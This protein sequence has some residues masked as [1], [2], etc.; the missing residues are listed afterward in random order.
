M[1]FGCHYI[2]YIVWQKCN[3]VMAPILHDWTFTFNIFL[4]NEW[5]L[6]YLIFFNLK[7]H[8]FFQL[9]T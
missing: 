6:S 8:H 5:F 9:K 2:S 7:R 3:S 1:L 4:Y